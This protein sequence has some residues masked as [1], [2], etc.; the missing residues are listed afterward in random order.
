MDYLSENSDSP[1][2]KKI[3]NLEPITA[4]D[5]DELERILWGELGTKEDYEETTDIGNLAVFIFLLKNSTE[6]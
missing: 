1:V 3:Y 4:S 5:L 6:R 2:I